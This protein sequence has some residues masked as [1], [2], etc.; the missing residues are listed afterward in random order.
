MTTPQPSLPQRWRSAPRWQRITVM[1]LAVFVGLGLLGGLFGEEKSKTT[2]AA[3]LA[4]VP[5][6]TTERTTTTTTPPK[7]M[8]AEIIDART[9]L[10]AAGKQVVVA[11]LAPA[12]DCW[13]AA[14]V[15]FAKKTLVGT[16]VELAGASSV[17]LYD[18]TDF[19][20]LAVSRGMAKPLDGASAALTDAQAAAKSA[21]LGLWGA[22]C[23]GA[24]AIPAPPAPLPVPVPTIDPPTEQPEPEP[25][26]SVYYKNCTAAKAAGAAPIRRGEPGYGK[27]LDRDGDGIGCD[28]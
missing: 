6:V 26:P 19:A 10:T 1:V 12:G 9:V 7:T 4:A 17:L 18:G 15:D 27:H 2:T 22:P 13:Q 25:E 14:A 16:E 3:P 8:V 24:D 21:G 28:K 23:A 20:V 5:T 11:G